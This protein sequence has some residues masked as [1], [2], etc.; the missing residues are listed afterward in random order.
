[1]AQFIN[2]T[3]F[4]SLPHFAAMSLMVMKEIGR[5]GV[6]VGSVLTENWVSAARD[7]DFPS[8]TKSLMS[9][10]AGKCKVMILM[11]RSSPMDAMGVGRMLQKFGG[12]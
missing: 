1:M 2:L 5:A 3:L 4:S 8:P 7:D 11:P 9:G 10:E 6:M 12:D